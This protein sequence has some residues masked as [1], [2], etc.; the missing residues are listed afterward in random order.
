MCNCF[1]VVRYGSSVNCIYAQV[2]EGQGRNSALPP[3]S[4]ERVSL[5]VYFK[6]TSNVQKWYPPKY[7]KILIYCCESNPPKYYLTA[8]KVSP[9]ILI[10]CCE[11]IPPKYHLT[12]V[13]V[14]PKYHLT[15]VKVS[16]KIPLDCCESISQNTN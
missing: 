15:A 10:D 14:S 12:A 11:S 13:K 5:K 16:P 1:C 4:P 2:V 3:E 7:Y 6:R 8:V 9:K